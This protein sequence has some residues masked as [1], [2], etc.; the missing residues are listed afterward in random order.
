MSD[1]RHQVFVSSTFRD[2]VAARRA[3]AHALQ[4]MNCI[5]A[6]MELFPASNDEQ[7]EFIKRVID[8]SDYYVVIVAGRYGST[9]EAGI[10]YTEKEF[11]YAVQKGL[12][13]L[14]FVHGDPDAIAFGLSDIEPAARERLERFRLK[15]CSGRLA[16]MWT[17]DAELASAVVLAVMTAKQTH[18]S[19]GWA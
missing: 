6:G 19:P 13:V 5:P 14:A 16:K 11:D 4:S 15:V 9:D 2:L 18:P 8:E 17:S 3:V 12:P 7:F 1:V 10:S